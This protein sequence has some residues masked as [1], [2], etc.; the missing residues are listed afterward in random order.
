MN[1]PE[2]KNTDVSGF[3]IQKLETV[4]ENVTLAETLTDRSRRIGKGKIMKRLKEGLSK[5][6][7]NNTLKEIE[8]DE[9][10][11]I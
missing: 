1:W 7:V 8:K 4:N 10:E 3:K 9:K 6:I 2:K 5:K 11:S